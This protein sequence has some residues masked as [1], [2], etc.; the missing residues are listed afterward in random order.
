MANKSIIRTV[1]LGAIGSIVAT[2]LVGIFTS[3]SLIEFFKTPI[4]LSWIVLI[5]IGLILVLILFI[6]N[7]PKLVFLLLSQSPDRQFVGAIVNDFILELEARNYEVI[8]ML[9]TNFLSVESQHKWLDKILKNKFF[10]QGGFIIPHGDQKREKYFLEFLDK[11]GKPVVL[12]DAPPPFDIKKLNKQNIFVG[13]DNKVGGELAAQAMIEE[14]KKKQI[15]NYKVLVIS[16][17]IVKERQTAF[18]DYYSKFDSQV[19]VKLIEEGEFTRASGYKLFKQVLTDNGQNYKEYQGIYCTNDEMAL[20]VLE[21]MNE[22]Q[23]FPQKDIILIGYDATHESASLINSNSSVFKNS[24]NQD[25]K[26]LAELCV[27]QFM[28]IKKRRFPESKKI[29]IPPKLY[30]NI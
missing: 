3:K 5:F 25:S 27:E 23:K 18:L 17:E 11:L 4:Q 21:L 9:P 2:I 20:G 28:N 1:L 12:F 24:V 16:G 19:R 13:F 26:K 22:I 14:F 8:L 15:S 29:L 6:R 10:I 30:K 7:K